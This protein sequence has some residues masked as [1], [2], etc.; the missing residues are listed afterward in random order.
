MDALNQ[1]GCEDIF[2]EKVSGTRAERPKLEECLRM[3]RS[4]DKLV[5]W[6]LGRLGRSMRHLI[7]T[8][9][10]LEARGVGFESLNEKIDTGSA[11]GKLI[12]HVFGALA[13]ARVSFQRCV[14]L[15]RLF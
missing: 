8:V 5:V 11:G 13:C 4:K 9:S 7:A 14:R 2:V 10:E 15:R 3:L 1:A 12:F 6:R